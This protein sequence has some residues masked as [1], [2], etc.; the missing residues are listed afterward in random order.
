MSS[1]SAFSEPPALP[2][3]AAALFIG[4]STLEGWAE[5][6]DPT[7]PVLAM[8]LVDP[9]PNSG[10]IQTDELSVVC[11]QVA[12]DGSGAV[13][14]CRLRAASLARCFG[15]PFDPDWQERDAAWKSLWSAVE[16]LLRERGLVLQRATVA[17]PRTLTLLQGRAETIRFDRQTRRYQR[18][19]PPAS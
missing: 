19:L 11:Q 3:A 16:A 13:L 2:N 4:F 1:A 10:G 14:Y 12:A 9:G 8:P 6:I 15:E 17:H 18:C 7:R 5:A